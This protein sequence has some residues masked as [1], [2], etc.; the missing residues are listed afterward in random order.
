MK[1]LIYA[2]V[3]TL[4]IV[5]S[6][7]TAWAKNPNDA[8]FSHLGNSAAVPNTAN[9]PNA[10]H[11]FDVHVQGKALSELSIDLPEGVSIDQGIEVKNKLGQKLSTTVSINNRKAT[12]TFQEPVAPG[13]SI[14]I[15]M[16]GVNTLGYQNTW[17]YSVSV[18]KVDM[19]AEIPLGLARIH[20]YGG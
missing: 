3:F 11:K 8:K 16:K 13:T 2:V 10:T 5:A 7:P 15:R 14:S 20:T 17:H 9:T 1:N 19:K 18:K 6:V 4:S 12:V